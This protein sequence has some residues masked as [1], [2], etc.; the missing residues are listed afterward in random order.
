MQVIDPSGKTMQ[1]S[2]G[3]VISTDGGQVAFSDKKVVDYQNDALDMS[4]YYSL[5]GTKASKG[6]YKVKIYCEGHLI[7]SDSFTLK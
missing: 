3:N 2:S 1:N 6:N 4:I 5:R 7:G